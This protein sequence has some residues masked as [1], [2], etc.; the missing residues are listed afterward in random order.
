MTDGHLTYDNVLGQTA[1]LT[2][3]EREATKITGHTE[4]VLFTKKRTARDK[5]SWS[6]GGPREP[7][8]G[9]LGRR[10]P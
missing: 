4:L 1:A 7:A 6:E 10:L 2:Q 8:V 5:P 9:S 3:V